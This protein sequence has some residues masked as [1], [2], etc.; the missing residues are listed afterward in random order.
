M[1]LDE[2]LKP[3]TGGCLCG[4]IRYEIDGPFGVVTNC[5]CTMCRKA[6]GAAFATNAPVARDDFH[7][8]K[9]ADLLTEYESSP[10]KLRCFCRVCGSP[11][12]SYRRADAGT[13]RVRFGTL[14]GDPGV[15]ATAHF[16]VASKAPWFD[17]TDGLPRFDSER[18]ASSK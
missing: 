10:G 15:R 18:P 6:Q 4:G 9:G 13:V 5:H 7:L 2:A 12:Y 11:I 3:V 16:A 14:D 8:L 17:I 1:P